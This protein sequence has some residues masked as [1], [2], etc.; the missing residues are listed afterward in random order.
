MI[1]CNVVIDVSGRKVSAV[2]VD[3]RSNLEASA[4]LE[5]A[6]LQNYVNINSIGYKKNHLEKPPTGLR[7][8]NQITKM[9]RYTNI[10][11]NVANCRGVILLL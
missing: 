1:I 4:K 9:N 6:R 8:N 7:I 5:L 11:Q 2:A 3:G 10:V